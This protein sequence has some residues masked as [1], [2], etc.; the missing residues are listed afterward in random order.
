MRS[1]FYRMGEAV[2]LFCPF[3][4]ARRVRERR[5]LLALLHGYFVRNEPHRARWST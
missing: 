2:A 1:T 3:L 4:L 5:S